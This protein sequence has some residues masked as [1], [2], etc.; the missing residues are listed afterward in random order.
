MEYT[1]YIDDYD[2]GGQKVNHYASSPISFSPETVGGA[3]ITIEPC[4]KLS[5]DLLSKYVSKQYLD[6]TGNEDRKLHPY[7]TVDLRAIYSFSKRFLKHA[8]VI[9]QLN[10]IFNRKYE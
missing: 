1:E 5:I 2:N 7:F 9:F 8:D 3:T 4:S 10:N 6:N